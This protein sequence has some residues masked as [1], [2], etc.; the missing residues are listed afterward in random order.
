MTSE[1]AQCGGVERE[2]AQLVQ[3]WPSTTGS[4]SFCP[5]IPL[6]RE[7]SKGTAVSQ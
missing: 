1:A 2:G 3:E 4:F 6:T 7:Q 5:N